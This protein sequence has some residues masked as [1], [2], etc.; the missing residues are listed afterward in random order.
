MGPREW[1]FL[2]L[3]AVLWGSAY[4][5]NA[6]ALGELP[7]LTILALRL[8][9]AISLLLPLA[10]LLGHTLVWRPVDLR[11]FFVMTVFSNVAPYLLV[12]RGQA[13]STGGLAAILG[14][15]APLFALLLAHAWTTDERLQ[16]RRLLGAMI[17]LAGV[18][19]VM[20]PDAWHGW[21]AALD[22]KIALIG[23][24]VLYAV[25]TIYAKRLAHYPPIVLINAQMTCGFIVTLP[26]VL[27]IDRPWTHPVPSLKA[28]AA[29]FAIGIFGSALAG[30]AYFRVLTRAGATNAVLTTLLVPVTPVLLGGLFLGERLALREV[31]GAGI[32]AAALLI[33]DGRLLRMVR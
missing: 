19:V 18:V 10:L 23:A 8:A 15:T 14:A 21:S 16:L 26:F 7:H 4:F 9:I 32:I 33:I 28:L 1:G 5:F 13:G 25:G 6:L 17:G 29:V 3:C 11:P 24:S 30:L 20:G 2:V 31:L 12:L 27:L 22:A